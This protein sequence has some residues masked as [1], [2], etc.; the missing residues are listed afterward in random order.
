MKKIFTLLALAI[1]TTMSVDAQRLIDRSGQPEQVMETPT[2]FSLPQLKQQMKAQP[3]TGSDSVWTSLGMATYTDDFVTGIYSK[4]NYSY[5]V[6]IQECDTL[7]GFYRLVDPYGAA[8]PGNTSPSMYDSDIEYMYIHAENPSQVY[9]EHYFLSGMVRNASYGEMRMSSIAGYRIASGA[10]VAASEWGR[11][12]TILG[13]I[14]FPARKLMVGMQNYHNGDWGVANLNGAFCV[15]LPGY[16]NYAFTHTLGDLIE[17]SDGTA[18]QRIYVQPEVDSDFVGFR[19]GTF[20]AE[21]LSTQADSCVYSLFAASAPS[22]TTAAYCDVTLADSGANYILIVSVS[23]NGTPVKAKV[24]TVN[25]SPVQYWTSLGSYTL[26][27]AII[28]ETFAGISPMCWTVEVQRY[29]AADSIF[30]VKDPYLNYPIHFNVEQR[31]QGRYVVATVRNGNQVSYPDQKL[32]IDISHYGELSSRSYTDRDGSLD[33]VHHELTFPTNGLVV[34]IPA[35]SSYYANA[36]NTFLLAKIDSVYNLQVADT[37]VTLLERHTDSI[38]W[39]SDYPTAPAITSSNPA[40]VSLVDDYTFYA[41]APGTATLTLSY[42]ASPHLLAESATIQVTVEAD[43]NIVEASVQGCQLQTR[44]E[45]DGTNVCR[46]LSAGTLSPADP[47]FPEVSVSASAT[48][49]DA[50][51]GTGKDITV[52]Y[53]LLGPDADHYLLTS[54]AAT[55]H[56]GT[57]DPKQLT[58]GGSEP[59]S[60]LVGEYGSNGS[61]YLPVYALYNNS[62]TEQIYP[63]SRI[64]HGAG[65]LTALEFFYQASNSDPQPLSRAVQVYV[66]NLPAADSVM[67]A[68]TGHDWID[69]A[70]SD[71]VCTGTLAAPASGPA[72]ITFD[73]PFNYTG[74]NLLVAFRDTTGTWSSRTFLTF[75]AGY[76]CSMVRYSDEIRPTLANL[77]TLNVNQLTNLATANFY[78]APETTFATASDKTYD[79]TTD[80]DIQLTGTVNGIAAGDDLQVTPAGSFADPN[81]GTKAVVVSYAISGSSAANYLAPANDTTTADI[82]PRPLEIQGTQ[83]AP[84]KVWDGTA[85]CPVTYPGD[86]SGLVGSDT[87]SLTVSASYDSPAKGHN[88]PVAVTY[89]LG[90]ADSNYTA[91]QGITLASSIISDSIAVTI[92]TSDAAMGTTL[93]APGSYVYHLGDTIAI[94][95]APAPGQMFLCWQVSENGAVADSNYSTSI[96]TVCD[97]TMCDNSYAY[98]AVFDTFHTTYRLSFACTGTGEGT[99]RRFTNL[100]KNLCG[101]ELVVDSA[102]AVDFRIKPATGSKL[103]S[104]SVNGTDRTADLG[105]PMFGTYI[106]RDTITADMT[107]AAEFDSIVALT[108]SGTVVTLDKEFDNT[109]DAAVTNPGTLQGLRAGDD[110]TLSA[111]ASYSQAEP[112]DNIPININFS[113]SGPDASWYTLAEENV[114]IAGRITPKRLTISGSS[115]SSKIYDGTTEVPTLLSH[116]GTLEGVEPGTTVNCRFGEVRFADRNAGENKPAYAFYI[117]YGTHASCYIAPSIDTLYADIYPKR[118]TMD[119]TQ[120]DTAKVYD[121]TTYCPVLYPGVITGGKLNGDTLSASVVANYETRNAGTHIPIVVSYTFVGPQGGNYYCD[122]NLS[123]FGTISPRPLVASGV[124]IQLAKEYDGTTAAIVLTSAVMDTLVAIDDVTPVTTADYD[125]SELGHNKTITVHYALT[126]YDTANYICPEDFVYSTEGKIILPTVLDTLG[127]NGEPLTVS[128][129]GYC[130]DDNGLINYRIQQGEPDQ[131]QLV[132]GADARIQG[133]TNTGWLPLPTDQQIL[134]DVPADCQEGEY[135]VD[136]IFKNEANVETTPVTV[137]FIVNLNKDY[138]VQLYDDVISIDNR[139]ERFSSYQWYKNGEPITGAT[140]PY[141]QEKGGLIGDYY[142]RVNIGLAD[143]ARTCEKYFESNKGTQAVYVYPNPV[144]TSTKVKLQGFA[145]GEHVMKVFNSY[146]VEM[147]TLSFTGSE[148]TLDMSRLPQGTYMISVDGLTA[149][150]MKL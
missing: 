42:P 111:T 120:V 115:I 133:F 87:V 108:V 74:E 100:N 68:T 89:A 51:V 103:R 14:T 11:L 136:V 83:V 86:L 24:V 135:T 99:F 61:G 36:Q 134:F 121:G 114:T 30:R 16:P 130:Q 143:E 17:N 110:V 96:N 19:F 2:F 60:I 3:K 62:L 107:F 142:V 92:A 50:Q 145:E 144:T 128:A 54:D 37:A 109:T 46:V 147:M 94:T 118:I 44:R 106:W 13:T 34:T 123:N 41:A 82:L 23:A 12:D 77:S 119:A 7:P 8:Y 25:Y 93:P 55:F 65:Q 73:Q 148:H 140:E 48:F 22:T 79:G 26:R 90:T 59:D 28:S 149:K 6:E 15:Q 32:G 150:A 139:T 102:T 113:I 58:L 141:Y 63:A 43:T 20:T 84:Y 10:S 52:H 66:K 131:Y 35:I 117:L 9:I 76:N 1:A 98:T 18:V 129:D 39:S 31:Y 146:G 126:G 127:E 125:D 64:N 97:Y 112:G 124:E 71:L 40:V 80:A 45:Y 70:E 105:L 137:T 91:P 132:F 122:D 4:P 101:T 104:F 116:V 27:D 49:A 95:P 57:I 138:M 72:R 5:P 38:R 67:P 56:N 75:D 47:R 88:K 85:A 21:Q 33:T 81:T 53:S 69:F 29:N 78:F